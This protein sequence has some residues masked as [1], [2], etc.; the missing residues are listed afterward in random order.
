MMAVSACFWIFIL[1]FS[2]M[3]TVQPG[4]RCVTA[5]S[6]TE[7]EVY[8]PDKDI[9]V[10][11]CDSALL[12]CCVFD[13]KGGEIF[14]FKQEN[15]KTPVFIAGP[16]NTVGETFYSEFQNS[17][18][19]IKKNEEKCFV[20]TILN[21]EMSDEATYYCAI[22]FSSGTYLKIKETSPSALCASEPTLHGNSTNTQD[23]SEM[24][25]SLHQTAI[26]L[27]SALGLCSVLIFCLIYFILRRRKC[28]NCKLKASVENSN[29]TRQVHAQKYEEETLNYAALKF[30]KPKPKAGKRKS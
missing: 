20:M 18:I 7:P 30:S 26:G 1:I 19:R 13:N 9:S 17:R 21:T 23:K 16:F 2:S 5:Q 10:N 28:E 25:R 11:L 24:I 4:G 29:R 6:F 3:Y 22:M 27:G 8:H 14:W 15:K 12:R